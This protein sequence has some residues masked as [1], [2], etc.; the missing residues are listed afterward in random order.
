MPGKSERAVVVT[1]RR[2][3]I[4]IRGAGDDV[5][6]HPLVRSLHIG[7]R[8]GHLGPIPQASSIN[9]PAE[10]GGELKVMVQ[11]FAYLACSLMRGVI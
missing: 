7:P 6:G 5:K 9:G 10:D 3:I 11:R 1:A 8:R 2:V 4:D